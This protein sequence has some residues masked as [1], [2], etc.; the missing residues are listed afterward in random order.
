[1]RSSVRT[2]QVVSSMTITAAEPTEE[3]IA[4]SES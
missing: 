3:P 1:M 2:M 4:R